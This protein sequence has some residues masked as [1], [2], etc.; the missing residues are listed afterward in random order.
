MNYKVLSIKELLVRFYQTFSLTFSFLFT[1]DKTQFAELESSY[2][3]LQEKYHLLEQIKS[4]YDSL[5]EQLAEEHEKTNELQNIIDRETIGMLLLNICF[6]FLFV[7]RQ[8]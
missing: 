6:N 5:K 3:E 2:Q 1:S 7:I 4:E 8:N